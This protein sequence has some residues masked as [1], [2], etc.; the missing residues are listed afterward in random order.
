MLTSSLTT[1]LNVKLTV[2]TGSLESQVAQA[3][4]SRGGSAGWDPSLATILAGFWMT[5]IS[6]TFLCIILLCR[7]RGYD[8][9]PRPALKPSVISSLPAL[10]DER[11]RTEGREKAEPGE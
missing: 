11:I 8:P 6:P 7:P 10:M 1:V 2:F 4:H 9:A 5:R 3:F